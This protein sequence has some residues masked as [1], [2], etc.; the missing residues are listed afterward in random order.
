MTKNQKSKMTFLLLLF[1]LLT[2]IGCG[3]GG[4]T[5]PKVGSAHI[6]SEPEEA[7]GAAVYINNVPQNK[8]TPVLIE[9]LSE[10]QHTLGLTKEG[11]KDYTG[12]INVIANDTVIVKIPL[13]PKGF[14]EEGFSPPN[15][16]FTKL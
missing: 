7:R 16:D 2:I 11:W 9:N 1:S 14:E 3:G 5:P 12:T 4:G 6:D 13:Q 15:L 10:G 8:K